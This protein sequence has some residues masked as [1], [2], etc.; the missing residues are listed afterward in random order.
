MMRNVEFVSAEEIGPV[1]WVVMVD[2]ENAGD[3]RRPEWI[4]KRP[5]FFMYLEGVTW[6]NAPGAR[7]TADAG[8][9]APYTFVRNLTEAKLRVYQHYDQLE[10]NAAAAITSEDGCCLNYGSAN[11]IKVLCKA[12]PRRKR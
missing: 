7:Y 3:L 2:G 11:D 5:G 12:C 1:A 4:G 10:V 6:T 8:G 9:G